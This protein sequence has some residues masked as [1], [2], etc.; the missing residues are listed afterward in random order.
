M[1][2][3]MRIYPDDFSN[4]SET[5]NDLSL[6]RL[7]IQF[8]PIGLIHSPFQK[9]S[10]TP[11]QSARSKARGTVE[12]FH[13]FM[14]GLDGLEEFSHIYLLY[15]FHCSSGYALKVKPFL[16]TRRRGHISNYFVTPSQ[17]P[18]NFP[19]FFIYRALKIPNTQAR[20]VGH[21]SDP[22][23]GCPAR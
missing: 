3:E 19:Q 11:I 6:N 20:V 5:Q 14:D 2:S 4:D 17:A 1:T 7:M 12:V 22:Q 13:E 21:K 15:F 10:A 16:E 18:F 9:K 8:N 23:P